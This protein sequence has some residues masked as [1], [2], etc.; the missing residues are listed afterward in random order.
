MTQSPMPAG[1]MQIDKA[2]PARP[3]LVIGVCGC[4]LLLC[5][6]I[7]RNAW[8]S[9]YGDNSIRPDLPPEVSFNQ[10]AGRG[11]HLLV[12]L[13]SE[14]GE[15]MLFALDTGMPVTLLD[16]YLEPR[17]GKRVARA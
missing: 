13:R 2:L 12:T 17:L 8:P 5:S 3:A 10:S 11:E 14:G 6:C 16:K 9:W 1:R 15:E 7:T 4:L